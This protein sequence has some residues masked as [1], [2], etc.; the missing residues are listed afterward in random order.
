MIF[1]VHGLPSV[2]EGSYSRW[3]KS[4]NSCTHMGDIQETPGLGL[5]YLQSLWLFW[6]EPSASAFQVK[7]FK[8]KIHGPNV[9]A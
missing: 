5:P 7:I 9:I 2:V 6:G 1:L 4:L 8:K 3:L